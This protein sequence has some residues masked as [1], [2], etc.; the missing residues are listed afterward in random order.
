MSAWDIAKS[1][2]YF[3]NPLLGLAADAAEKAYEMVDSASKK[4]VDELR[5]ELAKQEM[6]LQFERQ[7]AR[8]AQE[9]AIA[10]RIHG[11]EEVE[12]EEFYDSA[13]KG[14]AGL[15]ANLEK[16]TASLGGEAEGRQVTKRIYRFK[17]WRPEDTGVAEQELDKSK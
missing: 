10:N 13:T 11:A 15:S 16:Q 12:I 1:A 7:Q 6:K 14:S 8:I 9:I 4:G 2:L 17:G 3:G 5:T